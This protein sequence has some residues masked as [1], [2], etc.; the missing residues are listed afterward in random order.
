MPAGTTLGVGVGMRF[1]GAVVLLSACAGDPVEEPAGRVDLRAAMGAPSVQPVGV[2]VDR[3]GNRFVFDGER[4]LYRITERGAVEVV[5][6]SALP[7]PG[8]PLQLPVT[9]LV[10]MSPG[11]FGLTAIGDG[12]LLDVGAMTMQQ[13]F[14]YEP[15]GFPDELQQRT[16]AIAFDAESGMLYAQ[17]L[18]YDQNGA[19]VESQL[20]SYDRSTGISER[21]YSLGDSVAATGMTVVPGVG[22]VLGQGARLDRFDVASGQ[23]K[24]VDDLGRFG[25]ESIDG[26]AVGDGTLVIVDNTTDE[27]VELDL[28]KIAF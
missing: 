2:A 10:S 15:E 3:A 12:F 18:T 24:H 6:L 1:I 16:D 26:L 21:W 4:G 7:D 14:C 20:A 5:G 25:I 8:V 22:L 27:L 23:L 9:D 11:V 19:F 28:A 17:P 13:H